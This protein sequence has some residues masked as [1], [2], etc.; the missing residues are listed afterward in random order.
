MRQ[1]SGTEQGASGSAGGRPMQRFL[2]FAG[3][4]VVLVLALFGIDAAVLAA[5]NPGRV[6]NHHYYMALGDSIT[7]GYQP[8]LNFS[9]GF[10]DDVFNDLIPANVT[11][12]VNYAC[13]GETTTTMIQGGCIARFAHHGFYTGP[14]L[15]AAVAFLKAHPGEV[16][17]VTLEI[18]ANDMLPDLNESSCIAS[19]LAAIDLQTMDNNLTTVILPRLLVALQTASGHQAGDLV[20]L[21]YYN[22]FAQVCP[23]S[24]AFIHTFN[25]HL[26]ADAAQLHVPITDIYAAF[27]GDAHMAEYV[28]KGYLDASGQRHPY[29]WMCNAQ[30][31]D[32]HPTSYGYLVMARAVE[33]G[34]GLPNTS[35]LPGIVSVGAGPLAGNVP[36]IAQVAPGREA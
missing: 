34:L 21:N 14:Q 25:D 26:A 23:T 17:P 11:Q 10:A 13:A 15:D 5:N 30:F 4:V 1:P 33:L 8:N 31:H 22:P 3:M 18:G 9:S 19:P 27:G 6:L 28:C 29:T 7:F 12:E 16:S 36:R 2:L 32:F 24:Q 20:M 35:P